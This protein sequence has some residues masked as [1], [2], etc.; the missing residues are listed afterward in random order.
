MEVVVLLKNYKIIKKIF[1]I[2]ST[3][4][5]KSIK[6]SFFDLRIIRT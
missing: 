3:I 1:F 5:D 2:K 4:N 6:R